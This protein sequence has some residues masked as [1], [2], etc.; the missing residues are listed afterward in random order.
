MKLLKKKEVIKFFKNEIIIFENIF[1]IVR[2][3][4]Y[5]GL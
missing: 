3:Q 4:P 2:G 1:E 5:E